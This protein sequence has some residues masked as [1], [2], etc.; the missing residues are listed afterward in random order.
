MASPRKP[1]SLE[2]LRFKARWSS[3]SELGRAEQVAVSFS[4]LRDWRRATHVAVLRP[5]SPHEHAP[6]EYRFMQSI[7]R[8]PAHHGAVRG[9]ALVDSFLEI[10]IAPDDAKVLGHA[11]YVIDLAA[12]DRAEV[13]EGLGREWVRITR[14]GVVGPD[15]PI[16]EAR[17]KPART[18][19]KR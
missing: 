18:S 13:C 12:V 9:W 5:V 8:Q 10:D 3:V 7:A 2:R 19:K 1:R 6:D 15:G 17:R 4:S 11:G 16:V 14:S